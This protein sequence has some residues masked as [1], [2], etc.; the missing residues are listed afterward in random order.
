MS[1]L[2]LLS[3]P[4]YAARMKLDMELWT[5]LQIAQESGEILIRRNRL[6]S[7]EAQLSTQGVTT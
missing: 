6:G 4:N 3:P 1:F 5:A 7:A 2:R